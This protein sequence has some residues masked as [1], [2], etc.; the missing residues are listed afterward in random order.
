MIIVPLL[1]SISILESVVVSMTTQKAGSITCG[2]VTSI[3]RRGE[4]PGVYAGSESDNSYPIHRRWQT[5][6][7]TL[8]HTIN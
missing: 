4:N 6:Y 2:S 7:S 3:F 5:G 8:I 1:I